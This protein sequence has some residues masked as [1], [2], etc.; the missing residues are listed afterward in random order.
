MDYYGEIRLIINTYEEK[1]GDFLRG[2]ETM[3][4]RQERRV[5]ET[6]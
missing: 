4:E 3:P 6:R 1:I 5:G 2:I